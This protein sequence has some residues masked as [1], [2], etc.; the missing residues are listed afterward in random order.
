MWVEVTEPQEPCEGAGSSASAGDSGVGEGGGGAVLPTLEEEAEFSGKAGGGGV[1]KDSGRGKGG[2][3][4]LRGWVIRMVQ[5]EKKGMI[6]M[7]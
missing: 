7:T 1:A 3:P 5:R 2:E 4:E 6:W